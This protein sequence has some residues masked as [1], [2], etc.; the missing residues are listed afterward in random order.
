MDT[1]GKDLDAFERA[2]AAQDSATAALTG[3]CRAR[4]IADPAA[5]A[6]ERLKAE[7]A[8]PGAAMRRL[9]DVGPD[10]PLRYRH[11]LLRC[12]GTVLSV[13]RNW[14]V[15][16]RLTPGMNRELDGSDAPFGRVAGPLQFSRQRLTS[17]RGQA[18]DCPQGTIL[19]QRAVLK[20]PDG[21]PLSAVVEC[22]TEA[23]L[24]RPR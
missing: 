13:A 12:G 23:N 14:Y 11:V 18:D 1:F 4:R 20:L 16:A 19:S 2:L 5:I 21:R 6:A 7:M 3:W 8:E 24:A 15:P 17:K 22:Y 9:L 10:E